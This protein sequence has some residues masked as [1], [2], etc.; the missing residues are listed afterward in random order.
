MQQTDGDCRMSKREDLRKMTRLIGHEKFTVKEIKQPIA[1][2][3]IGNL[4]DIFKGLELPAERKKA[5]CITIKDVGLC[6]ETL[7]WIS[8]MTS[9]VLDWN[10]TD[11]IIVVTLVFG[12][13]PD[14]IITIR[15][16]N[17][18]VEIV[19]QLEDIHKEILGEIKA[20]N[21]FER[22]GN[23]AYRTMVT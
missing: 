9:E 20:L 1:D 2:M 4:S 18:K 22:I 3:T 7:E 19:T 14:N 8:T 13:A 17:S 11:D 6:R 12:D 23:D 21:K 10:Q 5:F 15:L 16:Y